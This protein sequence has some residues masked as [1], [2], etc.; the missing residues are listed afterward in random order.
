MA[1]NHMLNNM[2][3]TEPS[4]SSDTGSE[5]TSSD[6][7]QLDQSLE[8]TRILNEILE[9]PK[10]LCDDPKIFNE[11]F[12]LDTWNCLPDHMKDQL[13]GFLPDFTE[14]CANDAEAE[15]ETE[16][17][18]EQLFTNQITRFHASPL[19]DFQRNLEEGNYHPDISRL[20]S[21][22]QRSQR[23]EQR[24]QQ[25]ERVSQMAKSLAVSRERLL[26]VAYQETGLS[27]IQKEAR[28]NTSV[29]PLT[30]TATASRAKKRYLEEMHA[31]LQDVGLD[32]DELT[33]DDGLY[34]SPQPSQSKKSKRS[35]K[36]VS[37][38]NLCIH[39]VKF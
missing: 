14:V 18:V 26:R 13:N 7:E 30:T 34:E 39:S 19:V 10:G 20:R 37:W 36:Q 8:P 35:E 33:D 25:C 4:D 6:S 21:N 5:L 38:S 3:D 15:Q 24:F 2:S 32:D 27:G 11:F 12:S 17:T 22:I 31:I 1:Q 23:R 9:L 29:R 28:M 16:K